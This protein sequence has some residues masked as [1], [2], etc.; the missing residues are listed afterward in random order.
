MLQSSMPRRWSLAAWLLLVLTLAS[1]TL[2]RLQWTGAVPVGLNSRYLLHAHSHVALLGWTFAAF[3]GLVLRDS[4]FAVPRAGRVVAEVLIFLLIVALFAAYALEGYGFWSIL[5]S[6]LHILVT[7]VLVVL[8]VGEPRQEMAGGTRIWIDLSMA[9]LVVAAVGPL[10]LARGGAMGTVWID[11]WVGYYLTLLFNGWLLFGVVGLLVRRVGG[12]AGPGRWPWIPYLMAAG[13]LPAVLPRF[14]PWIQVPGLE[15]I[16]WGGLLVIGVGLI[17]V[18]RALPLGK[19]GGAGD[20]ALA[21]SVRLAM[22]LTGLAVV[23]GG[24]PPLIERL[25]G[26]HNLVIGFVH[27]H[28]LAFVTAALVF[29]LYRA[30]LAAVALFLAGVWGMVA[31]LLAVGATELMGRPVFWPVQWVLAVAGTVA[32]AG[33]ILLPLSPASPLRAG[34]GSTPP[35]GTDP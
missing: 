26:A 17:V 22:I 6:T 21:V 9:W 15:W 14:A 10:M 12:D 4:R 2:L 33:A 28:L 13:V 32:V 34:P 20:R 24:F 25:A 11:A 23:V 5:L 1:G 7:C 31:V 3:F 16:G 30:R 27:L 19:V 35:G 29:L 18:A 8:Y